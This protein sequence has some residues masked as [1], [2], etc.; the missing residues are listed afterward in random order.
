MIRRIIL[1]L[2]F[3]AFP[4]YL[5]AMA[6]NAD[7][8]ESYVRQELKLQT[9]YPLVIDALPKLTE[10]LIGI[11][12]ELMENRG[13]SIKR[14][15]FFEVRPQTFQ[16]REGNIESTFIQLDSDSNWMVAVDSDDNAIIPLR[17]FPNCINGF[18]NL[19]SRMHISVSN[20]LQVETIMD[21][22][23]LTTG[24]DDL[25]NSVVAD[26]MGLQSL[27]LQD[28]RIRFSEKKRK[29]AFNRWWKG[30]TPKMISKISSPR[31]EKQESGFTICF[32][33]YECGSILEEKLF[34]NK[35]GIIARDPIKTI[36]K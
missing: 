28:F 31:V 33:R 12:L 24:G 20:A 13:R 22:F 18:N 34:I 21:L 36:Y 1:I 32:F 16:I 27:A 7:Q 3:C 6:I 4:Y 17:G 30:L 19:I 35:S 26:D 29:L 11:D 10:I 15:D 9:N 5:P 23:L 8:I 2:S 14:I 25:R